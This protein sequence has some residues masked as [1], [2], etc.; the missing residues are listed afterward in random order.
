MQTTADTNRITTIAFDYGGVLA[1]PID[2]HHI[3]HMAG[4]MGVSVEQFTPALWKYRHEFDLGE[5]DAVAYWRMVGREAGATLPD[6]TATRDE[7]AKTLMRLDAVGWSHIDPGML[8]WVTTLRREGFRLCLV[9]NM[10]SAVY[11]ILLK[12]SFLTEYFESVIISGQ[13]RMG[14]PDKAIFLA[15]ARR[16]EVAP[17]EM[18]FLDDTRHN[19]DGA[20]AAGLNAIHF[21]GAEN[22]ERALVERFPE[23]PREGLRTG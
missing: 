23:I 7:L 15:A 10:A 8:R 13:V 17:A 2:D 1:K 21:T 3:R 6:D 11:D 9:S 18:L 19:V 12:N 14:K 5:I 16:M 4:A 20:E 22:L